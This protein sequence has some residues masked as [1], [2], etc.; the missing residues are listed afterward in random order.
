VCHHCLA[1]LFFLNYPLYF[2]FLFFEWGRVSLCSHCCSGTHFV[3]QASL[4]LN[5][6]NPPVSASSFVVWLR[7]NVYATMLSLNN[8]FKFNFFILCRAW[9]LTPL[10]PA[11]GRQ[12]QADF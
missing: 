7:L 5:L 11:L 9:W 8:F 4:E 2:I 10:I 6:R 3:E 12:R 1:K